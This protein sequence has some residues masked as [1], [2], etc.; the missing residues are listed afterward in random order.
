MKSEKLTKILDNRAGDL[1]RGGTASQIGCE[2]LIAKRLNYRLF[3]PF[4]CL[5]FLQVIKH[6]ACRQ[7]CRQ[8]IG[9]PLTCNV[10]R[11]AMHRLEQR[12]R[13]PDIGRSRQTQSTRKRRGFIGKDVPE[14]I[15]RDDD[16]KL[17]GP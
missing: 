17:L 10:R 13:D 7:N 1:I 2:H 12:M 5:M 11:T 14:H 4:G 9:N 6:H 15:G 16:L 8:R 3:D